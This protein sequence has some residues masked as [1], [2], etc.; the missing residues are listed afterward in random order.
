MLGTGWGCVHWWNETSRS[1]SCSEP[2]SSSWLLGTVS[3]DRGNWLFPQA[4]LLD[5]SGIMGL[6]TINYRTLPISSTTVFLKQALCKLEI[7]AS[8]TVGTF[9]IFTQ[10]E[11][12][13]SWASLG[14][15]IWDFRTLPRSN[16]KQYLLYKLFISYI[17]LNYSALYISKFSESSEYSCTP[18]NLANFAQVTSRVKQIVLVE[19]KVQSKVK[20]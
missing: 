18:S 16:V 1:G 2:D 20:L 3:S 12:E 8:H 7:S 14:L 17:H 9:L 10:A 13:A 15:W 11:S 6:W 19:E 4:E 5:A